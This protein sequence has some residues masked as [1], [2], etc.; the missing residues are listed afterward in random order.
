MKNCGIIISLN[1]Q[2]AEVEF[3]KNYPSIHEL[4]ILNGDKSVILEVYASASKNSFYCLVLSG[5]EKLTKG[6]KVTCTHQALSVPVG[7]MVLGRMFD[8]FGRSLDGKDLNPR[9]KQSIYQRPTLSLNE[10]VPADQILETGV[11]V[12]D[13]FAPLLKGG[14]MGLFGGAGLGKT[15]ML[16]ELI[17]NIVILR[18]KKGSTQKRSHVSVFSAVGERSREALELHA[19]LQEAGVLQ[20]TTLVIGQMGENPVVRFR[21]ALA[22]VTLAEYFRDEQRQDVLFFMDNVYR[23][24]QAGYELSTLMNMIPS[25]DGYQATLPSE[26]ASLHE[27]LS[28]T[29]KASITMVEAVYL[30][31][32]DINDYSVRSVFPYLDSVVVLSRDVYQTGRLPAID[33]LASNSAAMNPEIV[34]EE[35]YQ[36]YIKA[37]RLLEKASGF[38]RIVSLVGVSELSKENQ[39]IYKRAELLKNYMTQNFFVAEAQSGRKGNYVKLKQ[40]IKD[41]CRILAGDLDESQPDKLSFIAAI[42]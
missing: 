32:D 18:K 3:S 9:V 24:A 25:E 2:V 34:G 17:N 41:V 12:I 37:K 19:S 14:K 26:I 29:D 21:T 22:G 35:H 40:T 20:D 15:L 1:V 39:T 42:K 5:H 28:S 13:F 23:F 33:L 30:P 7:K 6:A 36:T 10:V 8:I 38:E 16:T 11:K 4:L 31:S 27:R